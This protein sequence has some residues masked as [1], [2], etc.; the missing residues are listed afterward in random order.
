[1]EVYSEQN[2]FTK[3]AM[4]YK[5]GDGIIYEMSQSPNS[6]LN[7]IYNQVIDSVAARQI[8]ADKYYL[9]MKK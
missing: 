7:D 3:A 4:S 1:M 6:A 9:N 8:R 5:D 2:V